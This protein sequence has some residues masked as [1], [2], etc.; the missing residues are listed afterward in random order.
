M[1]SCIGFRAV[2]GKVSE[3]LFR[4]IPAQA[5]GQLCCINYALNVLS[6]DHGVN[7]CVSFAGVLSLAAINLNLKVTSGPCQSRSHWQPSS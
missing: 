5:A 6:I 7:T 2:A 3:R 4:H 1:V